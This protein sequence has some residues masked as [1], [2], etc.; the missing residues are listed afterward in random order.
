[1]QSIREGGDKGQPAMLGE[2]LATRK[3]FEEFA[4]QVARSVSMRNA[5]MSAEV[6][7]EKV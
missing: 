2:D 7:A 1:M 5:N 6:V 3:A 4:G